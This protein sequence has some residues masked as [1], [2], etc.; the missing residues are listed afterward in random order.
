MDFFGINYYTRNIVEFA[1]DPSINFHRCLTDKNLDKTDLGWDIYPEGIYRVC[2]RY[3]RKY[4]LPVY[5]TEN[6]LSD[7]ADRK[8]AKFIIGHLTYLAKAI[9]EGVDVRRYYHWTVMDNFEWLEGESAAFGLYHCDFRSQQRTPRP[10]AKQY[11]QIC[12]TKTIQ[13]DS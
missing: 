4:K 8:R 10:S 3:Y 1:L 5:I 9:Q 13:M 11:A 12:K 2:L 6:G 7:R